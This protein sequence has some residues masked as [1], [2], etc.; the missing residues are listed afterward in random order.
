MTNHV[1]T[2]SYE[3]DMEIRKDGDGRTICGIVVPY[4]VEQRI[5]HSLVEV[6]RRG[7]FSRVVP[8]AHRVKLLVS[9]DAQ[10]LPIGRATLLRE[11]AHG[12]YGEFRIS[13]GSRSDDILEL[14]RDGALSEFSIGFAPLKDNRRPDGVIERL[15]AHLAEVSLVTF[16]AYGQAATVAGVREVSATPNLDALDELLKDIRR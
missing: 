9:H 2:R 16:G 7:V 4:D 15:A 11:E 3:T 10:A 8:N 13:K 6:F 1:E 14:V 12:L 5:H